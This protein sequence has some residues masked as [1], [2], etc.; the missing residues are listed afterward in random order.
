M[1]AAT[2]HTP[3]S[4]LSAPA[5]IPRKAVSKAE[6]TSRPL[7]S[8]E[9][10]A[11]KD[12]SPGALKGYMDTMDKLVRLA[13][14]APRPSGGVSKEDRKESQHEEDGTYLDPR[15]LSYIDKL[16]SQEDFVVKVGWLRAPG[17]TGF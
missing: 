11:P 14:S 10:R 16:S 3:S 1:E 8:L 13:F 15:L 12:I 9:T 6:G 17:S 2:P 7:Q 5:L 4:S